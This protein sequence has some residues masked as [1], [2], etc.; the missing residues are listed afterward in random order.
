[1]SNPVAEEYDR[2]APEYDRR[3]HSY[4]A[5]TLRATAS[6]LPLADGIFDWL[7]CASSCHY[8]RAPQAALR[9]MARV[10]RPGSTL[11]LVDWCDDYV[12]SQ[13]CSW[14]LRWT[15]PAFYRTYTMA[16]CARRLRQAGLEVVHGERFRVSWPWGLM[17]FV[18]RRPAGEIRD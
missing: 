5:A 14:W 15:D 18:C 7:V 17:R 4:V 3:W 6:W 11:I 16:E 10:L 2:L 1:M 8:F 12:T 13:L 9:E